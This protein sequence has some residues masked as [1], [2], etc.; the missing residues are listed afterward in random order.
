MELTHTMRAPDGKQ[1]FSC[2]VGIAV[3]CTKGD[4]MENYA[5]LFARADRAL[6]EVKQSGKNN[7]KIDS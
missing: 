5:E 1:P 4:G 7:F 3:R 6:Y 2:G